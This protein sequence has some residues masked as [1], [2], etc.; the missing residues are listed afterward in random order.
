MDVSLSRIESFKDFYARHVVAVAG[1]TS[2]AKELISAFRSVPRERFVGPG[3]WSVFTP[4]GYVDT[5]IDDAAILYQD[6]VVSLVEGKLI[7]NGQPS[8][9]AACLAALDLKAERPDC[10]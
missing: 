10:T 4:S 5:Q 6:I 2:D 7:N 3:P 9:H 1:V 8:L